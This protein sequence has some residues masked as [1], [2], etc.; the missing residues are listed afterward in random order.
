MPFEATDFEKDQLR[1]VSEASSEA[2]LGPETKLG[3]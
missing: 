3:T 2:K 1:M